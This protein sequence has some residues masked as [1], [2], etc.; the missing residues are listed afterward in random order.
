MPKIGSE[1][2]AYDDTVVLWNHLI[3][4]SIVSVTHPIK[5]A[6]YSYVLK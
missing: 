6:P 3:D 2:I 1:Q 5:R 4:E